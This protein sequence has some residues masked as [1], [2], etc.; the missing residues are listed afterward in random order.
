MTRNRTEDVP[1]RVTRPDH[2]VVVMGVSGAGKS[3]VGALLAESL[4][5]EFV[6]GDALHSAANVA[7]MAAGI[8]L[9]DADRADWLSAIAARLASARH[10]GHSLVAA[11]SALKRRYRD[12]L[13]GGDTS[14]V[15][16]HL[17][18]DASLVASRLAHRAGHFMPP[19]LLASQYDALEP[20]GDDERALPVDVALAPSEIVAAVT[21]WLAR[22]ERTRS[23]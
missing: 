13:R 6:D 16:V 9:D 23:A 15:F 22:G 19:S 14:V 8:P 12:V 20:P 5:C 1:A 17:T 18:G 4:Q 7:K 2:R 11:C 3:L 21:A 10:E